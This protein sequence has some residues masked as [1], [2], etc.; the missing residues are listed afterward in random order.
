MP[1]ACLGAG[2]EPQ[3]LA[4]AG[5]TPPDLRG[6]GIVPAELRSCFYV[7]ELKASGMRA[8]V[9]VAL[10]TASL[11]A[12]ATREGSASAKICLTIGEHDERSALPRLGPM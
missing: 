4:K 11:V 9:R 12:A 8:A 1:D 3:L 6:A 10:R 5:F 7:S 2:F